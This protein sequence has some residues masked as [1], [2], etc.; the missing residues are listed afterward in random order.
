MV[1]RLLFASLR[2]R[3]GQL[4]LIFAA[5]T[6][7]AATVAALAGF[8]ARAEGRLGE[9]LSAFGPNL[10]VRPQVGGPPLIPAEAVAR[11]RAVSGV[12]EARGVGPMKIDPLKAVA[13]ARFS[14]EHPPQGFDR[15]EVRAEPA[16]LA[17]VAAAIEARV[18]AVEARPLLKV[19]E[20]DAR[21]TR[22]LTLLLAAVSAVAFALALLSVGAATTAL[23][24]ERR[25]EIG[26]LM[27]LGYTGRRVAGLFAAELLAAA[28]VAGLA[29]VLLGETAATR[30]AHRLLGGAGG[31]GGG[32]VLTWS[33]FAAAAAVS[34]LVVGLSMTVALRRVERLDAARV[35]RGE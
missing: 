14:K 8:S 34:V 22:R 13:L 1:A 29:G 7:A 33:G 9:S 32:L 18:E 4:A 16:R 23:V 6:V 35:L 3:C 12:R 10:T 26:L 19:S 11:V 28:V 17:A 15:I 24:G 27:A 2:R 25:V 20:S 21:V 5:V 31:A 30:L